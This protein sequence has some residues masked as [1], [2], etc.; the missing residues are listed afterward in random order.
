MSTEYALFLF[1]SGVVVGAIVVLLALG[2]F[3]HL[4]SEFN[5]R[6]AG[7]GGTGRAGGG[8]SSDGGRPG[9]GSSGG[10]G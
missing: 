7:K 8:S 2:E 9:G 6:Q 5:R 4:L 10:G 3:V 1:G